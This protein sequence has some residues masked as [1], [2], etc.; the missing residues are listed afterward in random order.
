MKTSLSGFFMAIFLGAS[1]FGLCKTIDLQKQNEALNF[2]ITGLNATLVLTQTDLKTA[3]ENLDQASQKNLQLE[4]NI[5]LLHNQLAQ[6]EERIA[7]DKKNIGMLSR[8]YQ[9]V[10][11]INTF[12]LERSNEM[13]NQYMRLE[14]ENNEM[15]KTLSSEAEIKKA[16]K[17]LKKRPVQKSKKK[18]RRAPASVISKKQQKKPK[19][20]II[21]VPRPPDVST[22][23]NQGFVVKDGKPTLADSVDIKVIPVETNTLLSGE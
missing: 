21:N 17:E 2:T 14:F 5:N 3:K 9:Q 10:K 12:L 15:K 18:V 23:G 4:G 19:E 1:A 16:L 22:E 20:K 11:K 6:T 7:T 13:G 8:A